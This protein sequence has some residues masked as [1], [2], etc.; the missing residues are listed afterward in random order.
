MEKQEQAK[1][2]DKEFRQILKALV[3][4][5]VI[6]GVRSDLK[7][8]KKSLC[9]Q[10]DKSLY[11]RTECEKCSLCIRPKR[12]TGHFDNLKLDSRNVTNSMTFA[13]KS[14]NQN[15]IIFLNKI[16]TAVIDVIPFT[17]MAFPQFLPF[18][19]FS[20]LRNPLALIILA[21][22]LCKKDL[23]FTVSESFA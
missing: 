17:W 18:V 4:M 23:S 22:A 10:L 9:H 5:L 21:F 7:D 8:E 19:I 12:E 11:Y 3:I 2:Y 20:I 6:A 16:Q 14:S 13:T 1:Q 15:F